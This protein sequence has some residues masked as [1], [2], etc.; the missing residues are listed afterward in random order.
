MKIYFVLT[1]ILV[2]W[3]LTIPFAVNTACKKSTLTETT[4][5]TEVT[6]QR[7]T[8]KEETETVSVLKAS[9]D[10]VTEVALYD[11]IVG[12][13]A[14]EMP[15]SF[16]EEALKAQAVASYT[17]AKYLKENNG[18][19]TVIS[20]SPSVHQSYIDK[21]T[22]KEKWGEYYDEY[23]SKIEAAVNDITGEFLTFDGKTAMTVFHA[24]SENETNSA[25]EIW[26]NAV[27]YLVSVEAPSEE[28]AKK[29]FDFTEEEFRRLFKENGAVTFTQAD[30]KKW[31]KITEKS[32]NGYIRK[33]AVGNKTF[34]SA[35]VADILSLPSSNFTAKY[36]DGYF[37]FTAYGKGHGV[38]MS[39]YGAEYMAQNGKDYAEILAHFYPGTALAK[40]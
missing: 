9:T 36:K 29:E 17:Y 12:T 5:T 35:E 10:A 24:L 18:N 40:E 38:G 6:S 8:L 20:D 11:Y 32:D 33:L 7:N 14:G 13:V 15:A 27:P 21:E 26:G 16:N 3:A 2:M 37:T 22:Q 25:E 39:Q 19:N 31:A 23:R 4:T 28:S 1:A 30:S 34:Y